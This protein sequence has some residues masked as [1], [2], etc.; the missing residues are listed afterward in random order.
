MRYHL[1]PR[2]SRWAPVHGSVPGSQQACPELMYLSVSIRE[3]LDGALRHEHRREVA[4]SRVPVPV[5][6]GAGQQAGPVARPRSGPLR[7]RGVSQPGLMRPQRPDSEAARAPPG[8]LGHLIERVVGAEP[9]LLGDRRQHQ[10]RQRLQHAVPGVQV[11]GPHRLPAARDPRRGVDHELAVHIHR[12]LPADRENPLRHL[13]RQ[14]FAAGIA[15]RGVRPPRP[16]RKTH[17]PSIQP[18]WCAA[19]GPR[20]RT[21]RRVRR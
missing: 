3:L 16:P 11:I 12:G 19:A 1:T 18:A 10:E 21:R 8:Q 14:R 15:A 7:E 20:R 4:V 2:R 5:P 17:R 13:G 9:G 6:A